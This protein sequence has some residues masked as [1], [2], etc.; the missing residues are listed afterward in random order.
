MCKKDRGGGSGSGEVREP[1]LEHGMPEAQWHPDL[2][3]HL[4]KRS[5]CNISGVKKMHLKR[6]TKSHA[7]QLNLYLI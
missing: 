2:I 7:T 1:G 5:N 6:I 3:F 4:T